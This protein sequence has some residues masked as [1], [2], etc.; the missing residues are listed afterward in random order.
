[1]QLRQTKNY[2]K[3]FYINKLA[4]AVLR[5]KNNQKLKGKT[6]FIP[7]MNSNR[8]TL[9]FLE[10]SGKLSVIK[11]YRKTPLLVLEVNN[12]SKAIF[13]WKKIPLF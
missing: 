12:F 2:I 4:K 7:I 1:M 11:E 10:D 8:L 13:Y 3:K 6:V 9:N 5:Q